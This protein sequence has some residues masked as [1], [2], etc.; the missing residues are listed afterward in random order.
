MNLMARVG[1]FAVALIWNIAVLSVVSFLVAFLLD[2]VGSATDSQAIRDFA[3]GLGLLA[4]ISM[5]WFGLLAA[6]LSASVKCKKCGVR[7]MTLRFPFFVLLLSRKCPNCENNSSR[8][9]NE[10]A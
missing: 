9:G 5:F 3:Y 7:T 10:T 4:T 8:G 2:I 1:C 6:V